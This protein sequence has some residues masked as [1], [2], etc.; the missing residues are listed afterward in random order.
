MHGCAIFATA[1]TKVKRIFAPTDVR[2]ASTGESVIPLAN[3]SQKEG[4]E[5]EVVL[6]AGES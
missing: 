3:V 2:E 1:I 6:F 4:K 5:G